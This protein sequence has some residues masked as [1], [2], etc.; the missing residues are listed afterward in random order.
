MNCAL[1]NSLIPPG[2][3][4]C[5]A[6]AA[7]ISYSITG[8]EILPGDEPI[9]HQPLPTQ[10]TPQT[11]TSQEASWLPTPHT[12]PNQLSRS[13]RTSFITNKGFILVGIISLVIVAGTGLFIYLVQGHNTTSTL[14]PVSSQAGSTAATRGQTSIVST[15]A[16]IPNPYPPYRGALLI[17]DPLRDNSAGSNWMDDTVQPN[18]ENR[19][20]RFTKGAYHIVNQSMPQPYMA[21]CLALDTNFSNFVYQIQTTLI[22]G[23]KIGIVFR[24][25]PGYRYYYFYIDQSGSYGLLW[26][27][28][29]KS[30]FL[31][32]GLSSAIHKGLNQPNLLAVGADGNTLDL[33][34]NKQHL[35][36]V[37]DNTFSAG[38]IGTAVQSDDGSASD[39]AF[40][41]LMLW[42]LD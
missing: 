19:G 11:R 7:P 12:V 8:S 4:E 27:N 29:D 15:P 36:S 31:T 32:S 26:N 25:A 24:Q 28:G 2:S 17:N 34:V 42:T 38:R 37:T 40:S 41:N 20:C 22:E 33:Y 16:T 39:A 10:A 6:C 9:V 30:Q 1:C 18:N 35:A 14:L 13:S 23:S 21:Y 3:T 5:P